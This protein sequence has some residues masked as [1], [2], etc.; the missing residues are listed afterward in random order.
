MQ[1]KA[2]L[3]TALSVTL[4][5]LASGCAK[6]S[7]ASNASAEQPQGEITTLTCVADATPHSEI[8]RFVEGDLI[9]EGVRLNIVSEQWDATWNEQ[10][11]NGDIDFHYDA[12]VPYLEEWNKANQGDLV[13]LG[14][15]HMEPIVLRSETYKTLE[16]LPDHAS[17]A[18]KEDVTNQYRCLRLL[19]QAGL[20]KLSDKITLSNADIS[21][22]TEYIKPIKVVAMDADVILNIRGDVDAYITNTNRLLE[23]GLD[24][25][26]YIVRENSRDSIFANV[27]CVKE[28]NKE[29]PAILKLVKVLETDKVKKFIEEKYKGTVIPAF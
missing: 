1:P 10:V 21:Y 27:I 22:I 6:N 7:N 4:A 14:T 20:I 28:A 8:L 23:A 5:V 3:V 12:Y 13:G 15:I 26:D 19:E 25:N 11:E 29:N 2:V 9:A 16:E 17:I 24:A 18:I